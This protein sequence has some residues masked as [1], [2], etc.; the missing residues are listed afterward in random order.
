MYD[1][2]TAE[3]LHTS[4]H[5]PDRVCD[6]HIGASSKKSHCQRLPNT[7]VLH[8]GSLTCLHQWRVCI[9]QLDQIA[10]GQSSVSW[11]Y[12]LFPCAEVSTG[13]LNLA[14]GL[15]QSLEPGYKELPQEG[16]EVE[17]YCLHVQAQQ[18]VA[19]CVSGMR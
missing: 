13:R 16:I 10:L 8:T 7:D 18:V 19:G 17:I 6:E 12:A 9:R 11:K 15:L 2:G 1:P 3:Y 14:L 5:N 4:G